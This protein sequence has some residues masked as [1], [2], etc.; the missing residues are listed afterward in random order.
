[1]LRWFANLPILGKIALPSAFMAA[2]ALAVAL[3]TL[4]AL[5]HV[6]E[7][8]TSAMGNAVDQLVL[9]DKAAFDINTLTTDDR[10]TVMAA[11]DT[12]AAAVQVWHDDLAVARK[13]IADLTAAE[14]DPSHIAKAKQALAFIDQFEAADKAA[15][16]L[17][18]GGHTADAWK[19][20]AND[21]TSAYNQALGLLRDGINKENLASVHDRQDEMARAAAVT[22]RAALVVLIGG[23]LVG[24]GA[25]IVTTVRLISRPMRNLAATMTR[26][27]EDDL[28][29]EA[30]GTERRDEL[31]AM[32]RSVAVFKRNAAERQRL[33]QTEREAAARREA[34]RA[35]M[36]Q[37]TGDFDRSVSGVFGDVSDAASAMEKTA[38]A[39]S[40]D[41]EQTSHEVTQVAAASEQVT[42][43]V[44]TVASAAEE[45]ATS[46]REIGRQVEKS[47]AV[48]RA[49]SEEAERTN[50][51][52]RRLAESS[53]KIGEVIDLINDIANQ[54]N[55]LALNAT[56]EAARAG[57]AGK[58]FAVV[59]NE[60]KSLAS[61]AARATEE[62]RSHITAVQTETREAV[63]AIAAVAAR[64][65]EIDQI[66]T[67][68]ASAVEQQSAATTEIARNIQQA[69][70]GTQQASANVGNVTR[71]AESTGTAAAQVLAAARALSKEATDLRGV[72]DRFLA[73]V[74]SA[75]ATTG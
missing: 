37:L 50:G 6:G 64:I 25:L 11:A 21:A 61:Q 39:L 18:A 47:S 73:G 66:A 75:Q 63:D 44:Q 33:E 15:F 14:D 29:A 54:T 17:A 4:A 45:L 72:T 38:Q 3:Y 32:A 27:A 26:L 48:S 10:D 20:V 49:A 1:M 31:G 35:T 30:E 74:R 16:A 40:A 7:E 36:D 68:I 23:M 34:R 24:C 51:T 42:A 2:V 55:L 62:I 19:L 41:A 46:I 8:S 22:S 13:D 65:G 70:Q 58:G 5:S 71:S 57:D 12:R 59:A 43:S 52:V 9:G 67:A 69:A 56:I 28:S 60:V 53:G